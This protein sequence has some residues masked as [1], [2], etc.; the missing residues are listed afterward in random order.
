MRNPYPIILVENPKYPLTP[1]PKTPPSRR[2]ERVNPF[3]KKE[4]DYSPPPHDNRENSTPR[5]LHLPK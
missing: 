3:H 1:R 2:R 4:E 5:K